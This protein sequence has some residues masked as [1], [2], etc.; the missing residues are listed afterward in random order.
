[1]LHATSWSPALSPAV[2]PTPQQ[3][4]GGGGGGITTRRQ[5]F[6]DDGVDTLA[7]KAK[8]MTVVTA[9]SSRALHGILPRT[10]SLRLT[11]LVT[12]STPQ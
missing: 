5:L 11:E 10:A 4:G 12:P 9:G 8:G 7:A 3:H 6:R 1:M 2:H